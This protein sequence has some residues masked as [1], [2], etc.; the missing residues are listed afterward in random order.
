MSFD[1]QTSV[2]LA[3][4]V[5]AAVYVARTAW[6]SIVE[7]KVAA[8]GGCGTCPASKQPEQ[9]NVIG[10]EKLLQRSESVSSNS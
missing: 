1:I 4:V 5:A 8:C 3:V 2:V 10:V 7:R 6:R 9:V